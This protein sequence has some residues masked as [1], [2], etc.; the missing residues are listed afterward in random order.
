MIVNTAQLNRDIDEFFDIAIVGSGAGGAVAAFEL[1]KQGYS[2]AMLEEGGFYSTEGFTSSTVIQ[3]KNLYRN[4]GMTVVYGRPNIRIMEGRAVGGSTVI[5]NG[6]VQRIPLNVLKRWRW[7]S[8]ITL[9]KG[10]YFNPILSDVEKRIN[11]HRDPESLLK[12]NNI[13]ASGA[14]KLG[15]KYYINKRAI[16]DC[17]GTNWC[18]FGCPTGGKDS[19]LVN[20]IPLALKSGC[21]IFTHSRVNKLLFD[22]RRIIGISGS[23]INSENPDSEFKITIKAKVVILACGAIQTPILLLRNK[24]K[25]ESNLVGQNLSLHPFSNIVAVYDDNISAYDQVQHTLEI[26]EFSD[27][28]KFF[29]SF[30]PP[31]VVSTLMPY[32]GFKSYEK[33]KEY[34]NHGIL[35]GVLIKDSSRGRI[36]TGPFNLNIPY[37]KINSFDVKNL[38]YGLALLAEICFLSGAKKVL[39][40]ILGF[41]ELRGIDEIEKLF[42]IKIRAKDLDISS[43][44]LMGTCRMGIDPQNSV[45]N[46]KGEIWGLEN[47]FI[48][49]SSLFPSPIGVNPGLTVMGLATHISREIV[50]NHDKLFLG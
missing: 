23:I 8:G 41:Q 1:S 50:N 4:N 10:E 40:P 27:N 49:D 43:Y 29:S 32:I 18:S 25:S 21:T 11:A 20:Y 39:L 42:S 3:K 16:H 5:N 45:T 34:I 15:Y 35:A 24:I 47:L 48:S 17:V 38:I 30:L 33:L 36:K 28:I 19:A 13:L 37:Y 31:S 26:S 22:G 2:V 6:I 12:H 9:F 7:E 14:E 46:D 44:H